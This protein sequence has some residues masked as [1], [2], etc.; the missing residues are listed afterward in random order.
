MI[1]RSALLGTW[2]FPPGGHDVGHVIF[3]ADGTGA[4]RTSGLS[5]DVTDRFRWIVSDDG[6]RI[7]FLSE[8]PF[9]NRF[10]RNE[11]FEIVLT[12]ELIAGCQAEVLRLRK[13]IEGER[14]EW[15]GDVL[16]LPSGWAERCFWRKASQ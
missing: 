6:S 11:D 1:P 4:V 2:R 16:D 13:W 12:I 3:L 10:F 9:H 8:K 7:Q 14:V 5:H 15:P